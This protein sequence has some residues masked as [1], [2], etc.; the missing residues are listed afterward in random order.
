MIRI[1]R[2]LPKEIL[3]LQRVVEETYLPYFRYLWH[4][5]GKDYLAGINNSSIL[6]QHLANPLHRYYFARTDRGEI[7]GYLKLIFSAPVPDTDF[8]NA[9]CLDKI[10]LSEAAKGKGIGKMLMTFADAQSRKARAEFLWLRVMD[11]NAYNLGFY[12]KNGFSMLYKRFLDFSLI[13]EEYRGIFTM[14]KR[15]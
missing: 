4:D 2:V 3:T 9:V 15:L 5:E 11:S 10:Y 1:E 13:K 14:L 6:Q 8:V 7:V 12:A